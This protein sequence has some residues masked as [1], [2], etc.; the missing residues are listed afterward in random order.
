MTFEEDL[1]LCI[2]VCCG[3]NLKIV[4]TVINNH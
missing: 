1:D 4:I 3:C 2:H